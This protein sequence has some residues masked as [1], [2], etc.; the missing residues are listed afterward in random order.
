MLV[1]LLLE[2]SVEGLNAYLLE[3]AG[4]SFFTGFKTFAIA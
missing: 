2:K 1:P 4:P 3:S